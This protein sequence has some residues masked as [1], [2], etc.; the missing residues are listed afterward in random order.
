MAVI[1]TE[2]NDQKVYWAV[3]RRKT[4]SCRLRLFPGE[5]KVTVNGKPVEEYCYSEALHK[6]AVR[7]LEVAELS[8]QIDVIARVEG[9]GP[10]GQAVAISHA[11][12][13]A[14][15]KYNPELRSVLKKAGLLRRDPR[16]R[17]R[18]KPGQPGARKKF[19]FSK[20]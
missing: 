13:R 7:P 10:N 16:K 2:Q 17:E 6:A 12:A 14:L 20:R 4:A 15:E 11:M 1:S 19:Q 5:G 9:S 3:G 8:G 18:K